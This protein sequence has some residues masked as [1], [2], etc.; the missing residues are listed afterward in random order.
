MTWAA[1]MMLCGLQVTVFVFFIAMRVIVI[2]C[3]FYQYALRMK[4]IGCVWPQLERRSVFTQSLAVRPGH[5][6]GDTA[7]RCVGGSS[8][9]G[10]EGVFFAYF[11]MFSDDIGEYCRYTQ[12][13]CG[14]GA[15][16][17]GFARA[18]FSATL[19]LPYGLPYQ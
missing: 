9:C 10:N 16:T 17:L 15:S 18:V 7:C 8:F 13:R 3:V 2:C 1:I 6:K 11:G 4:A 14:I 19:L 5:T 12:K